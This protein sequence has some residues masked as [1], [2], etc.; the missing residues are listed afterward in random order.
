[1]LRHSDLAWSRE[2]PRAYSLSPAQ[3]PTNNAAVTRANSGRGWRMSDSKSV[4]F[5]KASSLRCQLD[6]PLQARHLGRIAGRL[7]ALQR[8]AQPHQQRPAPALRRGIL[9]GGGDV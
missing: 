8:H 1:M 2:M 5:T 6:A 7:G 3:P 9:G 4:N